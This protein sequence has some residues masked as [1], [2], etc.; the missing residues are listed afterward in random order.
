LKI[1]IRRYRKLKGDDDAAI[2]A[3]MRSIG[4]R[5][6]SV[7]NAVALIPQH[8]GGAPLLT[9]AGDEPKLN[10]VFQKR[11]PITHNL[12]VVDRKFID[13]VRSGE[14][15][16][17]EVRVENAEIEETARLTYAVLSDLHN[18]LFPPVST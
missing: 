14:A 9:N 16:G 7:T 15:E 12:G 3:V 2:E 8:C 18:R 17:T 10:R 13:R 1:G 4:S 5:L 11:H 6:Q